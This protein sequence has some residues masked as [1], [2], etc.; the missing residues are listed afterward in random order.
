MGNK[1]AAI[2]LRVSTKDQST[3]AQLAELTQLVERRGWPYRVF[4]DKGQN[5]AKESRPAFDE[6]MGEVRR[7]RISAIC[8]WAVDRLARSLRQLRSNN[9]ELI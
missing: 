6:M 2:H 1:V 9:G 7:G 8:I 5:G 4:C 3:G